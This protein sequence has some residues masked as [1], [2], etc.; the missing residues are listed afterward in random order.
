MSKTG[1]IQNLSQDQVS[2]QNKSGC[3]LDDCEL[4]TKL[5]T[6]DSL[7]EKSNE[8]NKKDSGGRWNI[9]PSIALRESVSNTILSAQHGSVNKRE[10]SR[11]LSNL[12]LE[13]SALEACQCSA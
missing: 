6:R 9:P 1:H 13:G 8:K 7:G 11:K 10:I 4:A 2:A 5:Q 3:L 12:P